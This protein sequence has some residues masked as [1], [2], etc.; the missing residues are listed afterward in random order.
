MGRIRDRGNDGGDT[1]R[2]FTLTKFVNEYNWTKGAELGVHDGV[3]FKYLVQNCPNLEL[4]GVDLYEAQPDNNGP[5]KWTPGENGHLW[6][7]EDYYNDVKSFCEK[8]PGKAHIFKDY[9]TNVADKF[10]NETFD[11]VFV[12]ADHGYEGC[13]R[14]IKAWAPKVKKGG[15]VIGHDIHFPSV[16]Q[17]VTE[18]FGENSWHVEDDFIWWVEKK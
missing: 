10:E 16:K 1:Y 3:N 18:Y 14:D 17:A 11:F 13:L 7:H 4:I 6:K 5:E 8:Y 12:D 15:R 2:W 9:T